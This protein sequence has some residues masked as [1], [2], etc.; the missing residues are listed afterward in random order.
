[1][2]TIPA[3]ARLTR[4]MMNKARP[5]RLWTVLIAVDAFVLGGLV[6]VLLVRQL[7]VTIMLR[8]TSAA[9]QAEVLNMLDHPLPYTLGYLAAVMVLGLVTLAVWLGRRA[10]SR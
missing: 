3:S 7:I 5:S 8:L 9:A 2:T 1:M 10:S 6:A 4:G